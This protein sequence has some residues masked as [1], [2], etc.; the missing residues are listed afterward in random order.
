M[1]QQYD[2]ERMLFEQQQ[3]QQFEDANLLQL[4]LQQQE[5]LMEEENVSIAE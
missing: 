1:N 4:N 3:Q 2:H 5:P